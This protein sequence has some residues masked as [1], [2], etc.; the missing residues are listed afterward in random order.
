VLLVGLGRLD[1]VVVDG[2]G[3]GGVTVVKRRDCDATPAATASEV[4]LSFRRPS[5]SQRR[6]RR[7]EGVRDGMSS[8]NRGM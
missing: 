1:R 4:I 5:P 7:R 6:G 3:G 8:G 2:G